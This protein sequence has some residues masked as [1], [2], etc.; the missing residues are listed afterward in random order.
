MQELMQMPG[1]VLCQSVNGVNDLVIDDTTLSG[2][3]DE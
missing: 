1:Q 3:F 2:M